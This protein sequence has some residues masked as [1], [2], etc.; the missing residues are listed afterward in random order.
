MYPDKL[1]KNEIEINEG[2]FYEPQSDNEFKG[3]TCSLMYI[4]I[5]NEEGL[6]LEIGT[7]ILNELFVS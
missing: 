6:N 3:K 4:D 7:S 5:M 1:E 2:N